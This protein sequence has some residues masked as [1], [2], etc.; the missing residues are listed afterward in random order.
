[1]ITYNGNQA[2][3]SRGPYH[4]M[5]LVSILTSKF[6]YLIKKKFLL[7]SVSRKPRCVAFKTVFTS[8]R[9]PFSLSQ[10]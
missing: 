5:L 10:Y 6:N 3:K 9:Y 4:I 7:V 1:M 8:D 2:T